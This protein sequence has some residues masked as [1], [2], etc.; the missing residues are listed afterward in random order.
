MQVRWQEKLRDH[1]YFKGQE[2]HQWA[3]DG[4]EQRRRGRWGSKV[5][6]LQR[7][8]GERGVPL[9]Q[10]GV[11]RALSQHTWCDPITKLGFRAH[12]MPVLH[13]G[14][15]LSHVA[16]CPR[17]HR[18]R[19][20]WTPP[21]GAPVLHPE[22]F[23]LHPVFPLLPMLL[24]QLTRNNPLNPDV[25]KVTVRV[26]AQE[27]MELK[28]EASRKHRIWRAAFRKRRDRVFSK[29]QKAELGPITRNHRETTF[30]QLDE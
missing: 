23:Q 11:H 25:R 22:G 2:R 8:G 27:H 7:A 18:E 26:R 13:E 6:L 29:P 12:I 16:T 28:R 24:S 15:K 10:A 9:G 3:D 20:S 5:V 1:A 30:Q 21:C 19:Q 14:M 17:S 4:L